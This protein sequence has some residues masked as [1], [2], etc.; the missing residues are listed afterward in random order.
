MVATTAPAAPAGPRPAPAPAATIT[1]VA[2][3]PYVSAPTLA[4]AQ[5]LLT[6]LLQL[7]ETGSGDQLLRLLEGEARHAPQARALSR[8]YEQLVQGVRPIRLSQVEFK[9]ESREGALLVTGR[10]RLHAGEPTIGSPG[11]R[12]LIKAE[13][14]TRGGGVMLKGLS[15]TPD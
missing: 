4:D 3:A 13:F 2:A 10:I 6:Q 9:G 1:P 8:H 15:G 11:E 7:L 5:P 14:V 12:L